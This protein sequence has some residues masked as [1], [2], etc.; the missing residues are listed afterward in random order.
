MLQERDFRFS[1]WW[2]W[3]WQLSGMS[4]RIAE[5]VRTSE[6]SVNVTVPKPVLLWLS[7][8]SARVTC[9]NVSA[10]GVMFVS[11]SSGWPCKDSEGRLKG[12][13]RL[14]TSRLLQEQLQYLSKSIRSVP[15]LEFHFR[16]ILTGNKSCFIFYIFTYILTYFPKMKAGLYDIQPVSASCPHPNNFWTEW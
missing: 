10:G 15:Y 2:I 13:C 3:R 1:R 7:E 5:A 16:S 11:T 8:G 6:T 4:R 14:H 9:D 12:N